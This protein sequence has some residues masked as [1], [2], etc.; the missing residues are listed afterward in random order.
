MAV[1]DPKRHPLLYEV[2]QGAQ[3]VGNDDFPSCM[4]WADEHELVARGQSDFRGLL[5][6]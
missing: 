6:A 4:E 5:P 1:L 2:G 3:W